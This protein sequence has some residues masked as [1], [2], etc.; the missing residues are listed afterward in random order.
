MGFW[1]ER[2]DGNS[3]KLGAKFG[4]FDVEFRRGDCHPSVDTSCLI[5]GH[6]LSTYIHTNIDTWIERYVNTFVIM[7]I[8]GTNIHIV[9]LQ[10]TMLRNTN[11]RIYNIH[12]GNI[13]TEIVQE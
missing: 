11:N 1:K 5:K 7:Y 12:K 10:K 2:T 8:D 13:S 6:D 3:G 9:I 4:H